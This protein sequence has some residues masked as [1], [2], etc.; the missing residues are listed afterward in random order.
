MVRNQSFEST[1]RYHSKDAIYKVSDEQNR[2]K[3][4]HVHIVE[5][6]PPFHPVDTSL[7]TNHESIYHRHLT[8]HF[9]PHL[10]GTF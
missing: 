10:M 9:A 7:F 8:A 4:R 3:R 5:K 1:S 2:R 6:K